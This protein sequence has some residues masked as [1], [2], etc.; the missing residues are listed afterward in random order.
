MAR[1]TSR[2]S[3]LERFHAATASSTQPS[4]GSSFTNRWQSFRLTWCIVAGWSARTLEPD[5]FVH[6]VA[7]LKPDTQ[8]FFFSA[9]MRPPVE[10]EVP[11]LLGTLDAPTGE[12][13]RD[14][15][16]VL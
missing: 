3:P 16:H 13:A 14:G 2:M 7:A 10:L 11:T 5:P 8:H 15:D 4:G 6:V 9:I 12:Y 1:S